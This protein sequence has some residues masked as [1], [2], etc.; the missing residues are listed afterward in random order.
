MADLGRELTLEAVRITEPA[1]IAAAEKVGHG[2]PDEADQAAVD[3]MRE[4]L[5]HVDIVGTVVIGEGEKDEAP[6]LYIGEQ[7]GSGYGPAV[8][9]AVDPL[10]GTSIVAEG[11]NNALCV[12][13]MGER[14]GFLHA[15]DVYMMKIAVGHKAAGCINLR[16]NI[17]HNCRAV[18]EAL[19]KPLQYLTVVVL[20][21]PRHQKILAELRKLG[22]RIKLISDG[23]VS[24]ALS[25]AVPDTGV[26]MLIGIGGSTEGVLAAAALRCLDGQI[27]GRL[28]P[29]GDKQIRRIREMNIDDVNRIYETRD[30]AGGSDLIF[31]ATGVTDGDFL[32]G[33]RFGTTWIHTHSMVLRAKSGTMRFIQAQHRYGKAKTKR[34]P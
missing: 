31:A 32:K 9:I 5:N 28:H 25:T 7:V 22:V 23:D 13:A 19:R 29:I 11:R 12:L 21:R 18:A 17:A 34:R 26:D 30:M 24:A 10:E 15:P 8:D 16:K 6:M 2:D 4:M 3:A 14:G 20:D 1:A 27:Q 33:V